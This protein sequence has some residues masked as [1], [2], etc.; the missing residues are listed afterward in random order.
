M[1]TCEYIYK[2]GRHA[3]ER[4]EIRPTNGEK[5]CYKHKKAAEMKSFRAHTADS[6][7]VDPIFA[8]PGATRPA[9]P[10]A[11]HRYSNWMITINSNVSYDKMSANDKKLFK[12]FID[13]V[14]SRDNIEKF[15]TD[16]TGGGAKN[17]VKLGV[18]HYF[19]V[20]PNNG[21]LHMHGL[22][23]LEHTGNFRLEFNRIREAARRILGRNI[24]L[25]A[26]VSGDQSKAYAQYAAKKASSTA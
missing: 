4:C 12:D 1:S 11:K 5:M 18:E 25:S 8:A 16:S 9:T 14:F 7:I 24:H 20:A 2:S 23:S 15:L 10:P 17:I 21:R 19:E 3:G 13:F 22:L 6:L 26:P